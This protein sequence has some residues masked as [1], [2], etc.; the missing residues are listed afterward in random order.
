MAIYVR[1]DGL[2]GPVTTGGYKGCFE[3]ASFEIGVDRA[4]IQATGGK[5]VESSTVELSPI[6]ITKTL[7]KASTKLFEQS[8]SGVRIKTMVFEFTTT[9]PKSVD[10]YLTYNLT[11]AQFKSYQAIS[12]GSVPV[13]HI[14][15]MYDTIA[16]K[17][18]FLSD[19]GTPDTP[20]TTGWSLLQNKAL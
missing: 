13:E 16:M 5:M 3:L 12:T 20:S 14:E 7:D 17:T 18:S 2:T 10:T 8:I 6:T 9:A 4:L 19:K 1:I 11:N 15:I